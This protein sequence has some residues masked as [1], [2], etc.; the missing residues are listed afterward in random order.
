MVIVR[1]SPPNTRKIIRATHI[2][3]ESLAR[4]AAVVNG[5]LVTCA[6]HV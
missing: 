2:A 4:Y 6:T 3:I 5:V 1:P